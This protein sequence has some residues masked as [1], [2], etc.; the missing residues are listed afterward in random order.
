MAKCSVLITSSASKAPLLD[1]I[2]NLCQKYS[3]DV[4]IVA[5]DSNAETITSYLPFDFWQMPRLSSENLNEIRSEVVRRGIDLII[6]T[7]DAEL[8]LLAKNRE[9]FKEKG[10]NI[11]V[12]DPTVVEICIDK[13]LFFKEFA[14]DLP[15]IPTT[16]RDGLI[17]L[18]CERYVVKER[19]GSGSKMNAINVTLDEAIFHANSID[20]PIFQPYIAGI[21]Y[22]IDTYTD[23]NEKVLGV[24]ARRRDLVQNG[25]SQVTTAIPDRR[26]EEFGRHVAQTIGF[27]GHANIQVI[28]QGS[29]LKIIECN[30]RIG[31]A[32]TLSFHCGLISPIW[33]IIESIG[34]SLID[35]PFTPLKSKIQMIRHKKD[36]YFDLGA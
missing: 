9:S 3:L 33:A 17:E 5:G 7:R 13:L 11:S 36:S 32:S 16:D 15:V 26:L 21:E 23:M 8:Q 6:P 29:T 25:E 28:E 20:N 24:V 22:S 18:D 10:I 2:W 14:R 31:G 30:A 27:K 1:S 35:Y 19:Y 34:G 12:S 4:Q